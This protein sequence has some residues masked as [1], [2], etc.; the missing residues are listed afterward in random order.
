MVRE[1]E[2]GRGARDHERGQRHLECELEGERG[3]RNRCGD[4]EGG[5]GSM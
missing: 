1:I 4:L 5:D 3:R 2:R